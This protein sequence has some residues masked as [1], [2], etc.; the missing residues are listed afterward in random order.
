[1]L[2]QH[3]Q[4]IIRHLTAGIWM[5]DDTGRYGLLRTRFTS[6]SVANITS[7]PILLLLTKCKYDP[8][9]SFTSVPNACRPTGRC[10]IHLTILNYWIDRFGLRGYRI[11]RPMTVSCG[12][13][14]WRTWSASQNRGQRKIFVPCHGICW[15]R[16][17]S[18]KI[19]QKATICL[20]IYSM[21]ISAT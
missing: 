15:P 10:V 17:V 5:F 6:P 14:T 4:V 3:R 16:K 11:W 2:Y 9:I 19:T 13:D 8:R 20:L 21:V 12:G 18:D 7:Y 1:M